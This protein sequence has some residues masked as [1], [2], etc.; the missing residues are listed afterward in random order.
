MHVADRRTVVETV[1]EVELKNA[2]IATRPNE[3]TPRALLLTA[4]RSER[5]TGKTSAPA[6]TA[7]RAHVN[8]LALYG[9][10]EKGGKSIIEMVS[11]KGHAVFV[12]LGRKCVGSALAFMTVPLDKYVISVG[13]RTLAPTSLTKLT[14]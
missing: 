13:E 14:L 11:F 3:T 10:L 5:L 7:L 1:G 6:V 8:V 9:T 4:E 12:S 2:C